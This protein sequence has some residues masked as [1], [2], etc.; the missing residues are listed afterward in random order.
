[1]VPLSG[2][3]RICASRTIQRSGPPPVVAGLTLA[4]RRI[5][6]TDDQNGRLAALVN[7]VKAEPIP[8]DGAVRGPHFHTEI[9][10]TNLLL[11][12]V[13]K[14]ALSPYRVV[15]DEAKVAKDRV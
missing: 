11:T 7:R 4:Q 15:T 10:K 9:Q 14:I 5:W 6:G 12:F 13:M 1:V 2:F 8:W 3:G